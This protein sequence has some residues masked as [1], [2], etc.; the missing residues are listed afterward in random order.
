M[1]RHPLNGRTIA[2]STPMRRV[3]L[4]ALG[5][6]LTG[7]ASMSPDGGFGTVEKATAERLGTPVQLAWARQPGDLDR[8]AQRVDELLGKPLSMDDAVQVALL[9]NRGLQAALPNW[10]SPRPTS[11]RPAAC[12]TRASASAADGAATRSSASAAC[13]STWPG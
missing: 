8:I 12:R 9:N 4:A 11:C 3:A 2:R 6:L 7:C 13:T 5:V 1:T 10:A